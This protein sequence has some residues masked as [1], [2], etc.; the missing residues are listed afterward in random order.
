ML[1]AVD[2][3]EKNDLAVDQQLAALDLHLSEA[4]LRGNYFD[5]PIG[6][7]VLRQHQLIEVR[8]LGGPQGRGVHALAQ[9][10]LRGLARRDGCRGRERC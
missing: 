6:G 10:N 8:M 5:Q 1:V 4:D 2:P 9:L 7:I 3:F